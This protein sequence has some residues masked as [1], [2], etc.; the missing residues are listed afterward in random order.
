MAC[1]PRLPASHDPSQVI[2]S[3]AMLSTEGSPYKAGSAKR[4]ASLGVRIDGSTIE[5]DESLVVVDE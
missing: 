2:Y 1:L 3:V 5:V 4:L